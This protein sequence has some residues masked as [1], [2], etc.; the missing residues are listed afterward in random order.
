MVPVLACAGRGR[1]LM[2]SAVIVHNEWDERRYEQVAM[3]EP[4]EINPLPDEAESASAQRHATGWARSWFTITSLVSK[5]FKLKYRRSVLG[6]LW[7]VLNPLLMMLVLTAVF[8]AFFKFD[9]E[10]FP[11]YLILGQT[12]FTF[13]SDATSAAMRSIIDSA[14]LIKKVRINK[15]VFPI[16]QVLFQL[17]NFAISLIA[18]AIVVAFFRVIPS[19][20]IVLLP[21]LVGYVFLFSLGFGFLLSALAVFFRDMVHLW[22][23]VTMA[24]MYATPLFYP[25]EILPGWML[26]AEAFNPMYH[27]VTYFRDIVMWNTCPGLLENLI[28]FGFAAITFLVG[29]AVFKATE[30][31]FILYV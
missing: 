1:T 10:N 3:A 12:L 29:L 14:A 18:V 5:D 23:V 17:V 16:E 28:C 7:S 8:S 26:S 15:L 19:V 31:K 21:L 25:I 4:A 20:Y 22:G 24:W 27:Y 13:M 6:V 30:R 11:L 2:F 9:I